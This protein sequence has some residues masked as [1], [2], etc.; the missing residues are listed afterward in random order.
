MPLGDAHVG[1]GI[2]Q[3][4]NIKISKDDAGQWA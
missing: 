4:E 1:T 2:S 3:Q